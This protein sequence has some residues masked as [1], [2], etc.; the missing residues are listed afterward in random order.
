MFT[1]LLGIKTDSTESGTSKFGRL[2]RLTYMSLDDHN[3]HTRFVKTGGNR[4]DCPNVLL[5][6]LETSLED[7]HLATRR[8][9]INVNS[10]LPA[11]KVNLLSQQ[12]K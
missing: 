11:Y 4:G 8:I 1:Y 2:D 10:R 7:S 12:L 6:S 3:N 9:N 5:L